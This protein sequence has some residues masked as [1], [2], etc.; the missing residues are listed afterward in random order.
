MKLQEEVSYVAQIVR[1]IKEIPLKILSASFLTWVL[2]L[3]LWARGTIEFQGIDFL[4]FTAAVIGIK[5]YKAV[6]ENGK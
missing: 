4:V 3:A 5:S 6:N 2:L 1:R